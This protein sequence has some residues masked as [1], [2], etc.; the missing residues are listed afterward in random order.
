VRI[1]HAATAEPLSTSSTGSPHAR[2]M[3]ADVISLMAAYSIDAARR[4]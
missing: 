3:N 4:S 2:L 1:S